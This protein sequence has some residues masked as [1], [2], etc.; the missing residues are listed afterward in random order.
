MVYYLPQCTAPVTMATKAVAYSATTEFSTPPFCG[1]KGS[2]PGTNGTASF[3]TG[4]LYTQ[5]EG[6][7]LSSKLSTALGVTATLQWVPVA[8]R[9]DGYGEVNIPAGLPR[10]AGDT[11]A[12]E[13]PAASLSQIC[14]HVDETAKEIYTWADGSV[15]DTPPPI[16]GDL[17][18]WYPYMIGAGALLVFM[19]LRK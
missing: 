11:L 17:S 3:G 2:A 14:A 1:A 18:A 4:R 5:A 7:A 13:Q 6:A 15:H 10:Y 9:E 12:A 19:T 16:P 8:G